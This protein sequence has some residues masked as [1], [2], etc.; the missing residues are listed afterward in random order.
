MKTNA[1]VEL[2]I[3]VAVYNENP[4]NLTLLLERLKS[5]LTPACLGYEVVFV[6]DGSREPT[7]SAL[8][9]LAADHDYVKL[10]ELSRNFGQQAAISAGLDHSD[11]AAI[12]NIDS[13]L[14]D[15]P[16]LI[17]LMVQK[18]KEGFDVVY[19]TRS[20]RRDRFMKRLSAHLFYRVL[21]AVS[22]V[23]I[24]R[25]TGDFRLMDRRAADALRAL[26]EKT[27]FLRGLVPWLGFRQCGIPVDRDAREIGES[28]YTLRK[29]FVLCMDGLLSFS[30]APLY[31][32]PILGC[33]L[34][35]LGMVGVLASLCLNGFSTIDGPVL[36]W[37]FLSLTGLQMCATGVVAVYLSKVLDESR[38]RPT[39][40]VGR[41]LG[42]AFE[43]SGEQSRSTD[44]FV[45]PFTT[46]TSQSSAR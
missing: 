36:L 23:E 32:L 40:I 24:P 38:A 28:T 27:R 18:W 46:S 15:P 21:A 33:V 13:D 34:L 19:A 11:G 8:R 41:R 17:P 43:E 30:V 14:Q 16:E 4:K 42:R 29:L 45:A 22:S 3:I 2:S 10:I 25:D 35:L 5:V 39:Y 26:P 12:V 9:M 37:S 31:V 7:A 1:S 6:N 44:S 20:T